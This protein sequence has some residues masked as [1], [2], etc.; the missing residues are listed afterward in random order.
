MIQNIT[1]IPSDVDVELKIG[2]MIITGKL[3]WCGYRGAYRNSPNHPTCK[4]CIRARD[5][6]KP[7]SRLELITSE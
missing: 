7:K 4:A 6:I 5:G 3:L 1:H 2:D